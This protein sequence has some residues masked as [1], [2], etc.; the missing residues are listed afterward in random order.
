MQD[1]LPSGPSSNED[2]GLPSSKR[3]K[4]ISSASHDFVLTGINFGNHARL[5]QGNINIATVEN[6]VL[7]QLTPSDNVI[8][9]ILRLLP[10]KLGQDLSIPWK[11]WYDTQC[12]DAFR[13]LWSEPRINYA[14]HDGQRI[15]NI[16][17]ETQSAL[18]PAFL[19]ITSELW[20]RICSK[21]NR[22]TICY[23]SSSVWHNIHFEGVLQSLL[24]SLV[25]Q[26]DL[27]DELRIIHSQMQ[28]RSFN[29]LS[30]ADRLIQL[31]FALLRQRKSSRCFVLLE[32][33][34]RFDLEYQRRIIDLINTEAADLEVTWVLFS[35]TDCTS[36][37]CSTTASFILTFDQA[38]EGLQLNDVF[39]TI[40]SCQNLLSE[41]HTKADRFPELQYTQLGRKWLQSRKSSIVVCQ[42][43]EADLKT[44]EP[45]HL[46]NSLDI[47]K[48]LSEFQ[49][50]HYTCAYVSLNNRPQS[51]EFTQRHIYADIF[52]QVANGIQ[53]NKILQ[54]R[55]LKLG[56]RDRAKLVSATKGNPSVNGWPDLFTKFSTFP[57]HNNQLVFLRLS[58][59]FPL[60][61][62]TH[63]SQ[64]GFEWKVL[65]S[66]SSADH[67]AISDRSILPIVSLDSEYN[68]CLAS[69]A[70]QGM[71]EI[72][73]QI[74]DAL[75]GSNEWIW[76][77]RTFRKW[78][79]TSGLLWISG[80][81]GSGK[82]VLCK[83]I[84][85][86]FTSRVLDFTHVHAWFY[87][88]R[89]LERGTLHSY[90]LRAILRS[91]LERNPQAFKSFKN[92]Y[93]ARVQTEH[94]VS[95]IDEDCHVLAEALRAIAVN[96]TTPRT[97]LILDGL[98]EFLGNQS[99]PYTVQ[100]FLELLSSLAY[101]KNS[102]IWLIACSRPVPEFRSEFME[103]FHISIHENNC[104][105]VS[106][107][108]ENGIS[109]LRAAWPRREKKRGGK[110]R[111][112]NAFAQPLP[113]Q[114]E[115]LSSQEELE[116]E[117][118]RQYLT[119]RSSGSII[120][121]K[122]VL[123]EVELLIRRKE[124]FTLEH[125]REK[126]QSLPRDLHNLYCEIIT[127]LG[128]DHNSEKARMAEKIF[129]WVTGSRGWGILKL[130]E[131]REALAIPGNYQQCTTMAAFDNL[132]V[133]CHQIGDDWDYFYSIIYSHCGGLVE[134]MPPV[135]LDNATTITLEEMSGDWT[136]QLV[137][138]TAKSFLESKNK[139][140]QLR[141][142]DADA[143]Q[144]V[145]TQ[146][147]WY[148][149]LIFPPGCS[150]DIFNMTD[151]DI[152][153]AT[154]STGSYMSTTL[155]WV[156]CL[157][158]S[159]S[160]QSS[161]NMPVLVKQ[162]LWRLMHRLNSAPLLLFVLNVLRNNNASTIW[163][164]A[165][166]TPDF[167]I[168]WLRYLQVPSENERT[169]SGLS[170]YLCSPGNM[171]ILSILLQL[172]EILAEASTSVHDISSG[173]L[174]YTQDE[175]SLLSW[176]WHDLDRFLTELPSWTAGLHYP[177]YSECNLAIT[178]E[179][180]DDAKWGDLRNGRV[181]REARDLW[182]SPT[183]S[184]P[185]NSSD[186]HTPSPL[187]DFTLLGSISSYDRQREFEVACWVNEAPFVLDRF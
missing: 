22:T 165:K 78:Y 163:S 106:I 31:L 70:F 12:V 134:F 148:L 140:S 125:L 128:L 172:R 11:D 138:H 89:G 111:H 76:S 49:H 55:L 129:L 39:S 95:W 107:F 62:I 182:S 179:N 150:R 123:S 162:N 38:F 115:R 100:E 23:S 37:L 110:S 144:F 16:V 153:G 136:V 59:R 46:L 151:D 152:D 30:M 90:M 108:I 5:H 4:S 25:S 33:L 82:S 87:S 124:G 64:L 154:L 164:L 58:A 99:D 67:G 20:N 68:E 52:F 146:S 61:F 113:I 133:N 18:Y 81:P 34:E 32:Y 21:D 159:S 161:L 91:I 19:A 53:N 126:V 183:P 77:N 36:F 7:E 142:V 101:T 130:Q 48:L 174:Y 57:R 3:R 65:A 74:R 135:R 139:P 27:V 185:L 102:H 71:G 187:D 175:S 79:E 75:P 121:I 98:D 171:R 157:K 114:P 160:P 43:M 147:A 42:R 50:Q 118:L 96:D 41:S 180:V 14:I 166:E 24:A 168:W 72:W 15:L 181:I 29:A 132:Q 17:D 69:L 26:Y 158:G 54:E 51:F 6:V 155:G 143:V 40:R 176:P 103:C 186:E 177:S 137:H 105:D 45:A 1:W 149:T 83:T 86:S 85:R 56:A 44:A 73:H 10:P 131:L 173:P 66:I 28:N 2:E 94:H 35:D 9:E 47:S 88:A 8:G 80:T 92:L 184:E 141:I 127:Q 167:L 122:L 109:K 178:T 145:A 170:E 84:L 112:L 60:D 116:L 104:E 169:V 13:W 156:E 97:I 120:W 93:R 63:I 117:T 119:S